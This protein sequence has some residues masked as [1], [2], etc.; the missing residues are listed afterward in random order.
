MS[1]SPQIV[2]WTAY[3]TKQGRFS[4]YQQLRKR[5]R[6]SSFSIGSVDFEQNGNCI[7]IFDHLSQD[8]LFT[9]QYS[10]DYMTL[11]NK[12]TKYITQ[13]ELYRDSCD[14]MREVPSLVFWNKLFPIHNCIVSDIKQTVDGRRFWESQVRRGLAKG[15]QVLFVNK[16]NK[17]SIPL[18]DLDS[19]HTQIDSLHEHWV[20]MIRKVT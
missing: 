17:T 16:S 13:I 1:C 8:V 2:D 4:I 7:C 14:Q 12:H 18:L 5:G 3:Q 10:D 20:L 11:D 9:V 6:W 19:F 15:C